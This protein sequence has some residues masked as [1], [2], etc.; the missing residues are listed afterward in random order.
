MKICL[1]IAPL[2]LYSKSREEEPETCQHTLNCNHTQNESNH[3]LCSASAPLSGDSCIEVYTPQNLCNNITDVSASY[4]IETN[5]TDSRIFVKVL[6]PKVKVFMTNII[7][8]SIYT[9]P[10]KHILHPK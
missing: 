2:L 9:D 3:Y 7:M 10:S 6:Q 5:W 8:S 4:D 1:M